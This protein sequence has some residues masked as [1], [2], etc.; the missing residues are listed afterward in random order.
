MANFKSL[1]Q[2]I[3]QGE[4]RFI[5]YDSLGNFYCRA[6]KCYDIDCKCICK[7]ISEPLTEDEIAIL[8]GILKYKIEI[9]KKK[10]S[11]Y[12]LPTLFRSSLRKRINTLTVIKD[13]LLSY[14]Y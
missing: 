5:S 12:S 8:I 13:K 2:E 10:I 6:L 7:P 4:C 11:H 14:D 1:K 3:E 9:L